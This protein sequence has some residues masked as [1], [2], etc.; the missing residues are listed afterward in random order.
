MFQLGENRADKTAFLVSPEATWLLTAKTQHGH[1]SKDRNLKCS[2]IIILVSKI[3]RIF[4]CFLRLTTNI[5]DTQS[6]PKL[7]IDS[8]LAVNYTKRYYLCLLHSHVHSENEF[9]QE[10][11]HEKGSSEKK[12]NPNSSSP[13]LVKWDYGTIQRQIYL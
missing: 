11:F 12:K 5:A 4:F 6:E 9:I 13:V 8:P 7:K 1:N 3:K 10:Y 2:S